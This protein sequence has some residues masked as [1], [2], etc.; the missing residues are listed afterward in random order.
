MKQKQVVVVVSFLLPLLAFLSNL[1]LAFSDD[2]TERVLDVM[3]NPLE[4]DRQY[5][6]LPATRGGGLKLAKTGNSECPLTV[7]QDSSPYFDGR[8]IKF[9]TAGDSSEIR[10]GTNLDIEFVNKPK[11]A[12]SGKWGVLFDVQIYRPCVVIDGPNSKFQIVK[13]GAGYKLMFCFDGGCLDIGRLDAQNDEDGR[14]LTPSA[15]EP[16]EIVFVEAFE[17]NNVIK[18]VV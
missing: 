8:S 13:Y 4:T 3:K 5:Y 11:C 2:A 12:K 9:I 16:F 1:P 6:I 14:R 7:L 10:T 17:D 18:S 15:P